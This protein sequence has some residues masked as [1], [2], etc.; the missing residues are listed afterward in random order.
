MSQQQKIH[1]EFGNPDH[2]WLP[3]RFSHK[4]FSIELD[5]S[6]VPIDPIAQLCDTLIELFN[7]IIDPSLVVWHLEPYCYYL[8]LGRLD[9]EYIAEILESDDLNSPIKPTIEIVGTF[10]EII[11]PL[12]EALKKFWSKSVNSPHW[13]E[14]DPKKIEKLTQLILEK[15]S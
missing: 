15:R 14:Q 2:G 1:I 13:E 8:K 4:D 10:E 5:V 3:I 6:D 7:G 11:L 12:F 9:N